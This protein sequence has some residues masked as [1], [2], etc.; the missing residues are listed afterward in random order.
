MAFSFRE[1]V[2]E[3]T[4]ELAE[5]LV[6]KNHDYGDS[7]AKSVEEYGS[8]VTLVRLEDKLNRLKK[9]LITGDLKVA[10]SVEETLQDLAGYAI[11]ELERR[12]R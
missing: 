1:R 10:E 8:V 6:R 12:L 3:L 2:Q 5:T 11:L 7:Y 4:D 9:A